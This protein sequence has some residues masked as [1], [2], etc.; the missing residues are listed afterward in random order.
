MEPV[1]ENIIS[2]I[3]KLLTMAERGTK[4]EKEIAFF[5]AQELLAKHHLSIGDVLDI[6]KEKVANIIIEV[7]VKKR[8]Y[9]NIA[10]I[11]AD[12]FRCMLYIQHRGS[13]VVYPVFLGMETD[14]VVAGEI[15]KAALAFAKKEADRVA[16]YYYNKTG[17]SAGVRE[18][19][20]HGFVNGLNSGFK[21]QVI[22]SS[23]TAIMVVIPKEVDDAYK[24]LKFSKRRTTLTSADRNHDPNINQAGYNNGFEFANNRKQKALSE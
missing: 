23:E 10:N 14:A 6:N 9:C 2:R 16:H 13:G 18:E 12:N 24:N 7:N 17:A 22:S 20:L 15:A 5:K 1:A 21:A 8:G 19:W 4:H 3:K 11:I